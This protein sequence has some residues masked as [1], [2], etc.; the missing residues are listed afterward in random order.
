MKLHEVAQLKITPQHLR[1]A[2]GNANHCVV[3]MDPAKFLELTTDSS[4][5][6]NDIKNTCKTVDDYNRWAEE[7]SNILMPFLWIE[8]LDDPRGTYEPGGAGRITGHEGRHRAAALMCAGG[9]EI[10]VSIRLKPIQRHHDKYGVW[11]SKYNMRFEDVPKYIFGQFGRGL[12]LKSDLRVIHD[13]W[14]AIRDAQ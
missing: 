2:R 9:K 8:F 4:V 1:Q 3:G 14:A 7:G 10:P 11:D 5:T 13:G 12:A 6:L